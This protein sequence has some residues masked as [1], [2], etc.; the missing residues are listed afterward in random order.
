M[1]YRDEMGHK[2]T[3]VKRVRIVDGQE[4]TTWSREILSCNGLL[5]EAGTNG[6]KGGDWGHGSRVFLR[7]EDLGGTS[8]CSRVDDQEL[9]EQ[10]GKIVIALGGDCELD[11]LKEALRWWLSILEAQSE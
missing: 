9:N 1:Y 5:A 11:T 6:A 2:C 4:R 10:Q 7:L 8:F 3:A